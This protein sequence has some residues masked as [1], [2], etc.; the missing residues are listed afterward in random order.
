MGVPQNER[1]QVWL[2]EVNL[3]SAAN[4]IEIAEFR[5]N[6]LSCI[7]TRAA[8]FCSQI[9]TLNLATLRMF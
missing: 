9:N 6:P 7:S 4:K 8:Q 3:I 5:R 2:A 1:T